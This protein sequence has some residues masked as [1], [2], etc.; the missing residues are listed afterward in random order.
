MT[1]APSARRLV[2]RLALVGL[3]AVFVSA[4]TGC[5]NNGSA[6]AATVRFTDDKGE[7][8]ARIK[9]DQ[10]MQELRDYVGNKELIKAVAANP[11]LHLVG[12]ATSSTDPRFTAQLLG[13]DI[14]QAAF[15]A[16]FNEH[17]LKVTPELRQQ[18]TQQ[19]KQ[20]YALQNEMTT[21]PS[22]GQ[23]TFIGP[24]VIFNAFPKSTQDRLVEQAARQLA[25]QDSLNSCPSGRMV[26]H[27]LLR[28]RA[29]ADAA[30]QE[31]KNGASFTDVAKK[32]SI[33]PSG[34]QGGLLGC[35]CPGE[36]VKEFQDVADKVPL[37]VVTVPV[38]SKFGYHLI[39]VQKFDPALAQSNQ[40]VQQSVQSC[41]QGAITDRLKHVTVDPRFGTWDGQQFTVTPPV[42]PNPRNDRTPLKSTTTTAPAVQQQG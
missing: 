39:L 32:E 8:I 37:D 15:D 40:S 10:F 9:R 17:N 2:R 3:V 25:V 21:D 38:Q 41:A 20:R 4:A 27:I 31:I 26:S 5:S 12:D 23:Q 11:Q 19:V 18:A 14:A 22:T 36:F 28:D 33:D 42:V 16:E 1:K 30:Y 7:H 6:D 29:A 24:G 13:E 34:K 35:L